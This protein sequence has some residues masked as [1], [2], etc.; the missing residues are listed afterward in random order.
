MYKHAFFLHLA[1]AYC[2]PHFQPSE[3]H[4]NIASHF[5]ID[6]VVSTCLCHIICAI[7]VHLY[8]QL[9]HLVPLHCFD[10]P[11]ISEIHNLDHHFVIIFHIICHH[12]V[13]NRRISKMA[14]LTRQ[15]GSIGHSRS[16]NYTIIHLVTCLSIQHG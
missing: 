4:T 9:P 7:Y 3:S 12:F 10:F 2:F 15:F 5:A 8:L 11:R 1:S 16:T 14:T 6:V 13:T